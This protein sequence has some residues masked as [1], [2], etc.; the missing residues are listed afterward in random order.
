MVLLYSIMTTGNH[1]TILGYQYCSYL[2][3][4]QGGGGGGRGR[5]REKE[6][7]EEEVVE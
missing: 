3:K 2:R 6:E 5:R 7:E 4:E 1:L